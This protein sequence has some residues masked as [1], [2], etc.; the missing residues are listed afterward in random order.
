MDKPARVVLQF[1]KM[2][3]ALWRTFA[4]KADAKAIYELTDGAAVV[5]TVKNFSMSDHQFIQLKVAVNKG[6]ETVVWMPRNFLKAIVEGNSD[7]SYAF[8]FAGKM[9]K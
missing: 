1:D 8:T 3:Y 9:K 6:Q 7:P 2:G 5:L 4:D